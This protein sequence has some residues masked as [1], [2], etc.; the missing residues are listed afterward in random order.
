MI[1]PHKISIDRI[2]PNYISGWCYHRIRKGEV[3]NLCIRYD[4]EPIAETLADRF[5]EDL[6]ELNMH[7]T[8]KCGFEFILDPPLSFDEISSITLTLRNS[9]KPLVIIEPDGYRFGTPFTALFERTKQLF[10]MQF[11]RTPLVLFMHI[12]KTA[13]TTFNTDLQS[14]V[15]T[16]KISQHIELEKPDRLSS[17]G[18]NKA[19]LSG[20]LRFGLL[21][22]YFHEQEYL[23]Y[24]I[25]RDPYNHLHSHLN[26]M[27]KTA[28]GND[29]NYFKYSNPIIYR[30]GQKLAE[31]QFNYPPDLQAFVEEISPLE[32]RFFDNLQTRYF[33]R[34]EIDRVT[35]NNLEE[36]ISNLRAFQLVG[37]TEAYESFLKTFIAQH[38]FKTMSTDRQLNRS[39]A[40]PLFDTADEG[41]QNT[42][43]PL[44]QYDV[45]LYNTI[46]KQWAEHSGPTPERR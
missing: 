7:P 13:G 10:S 11:R 8:G 34:N 25:V 18:R 38:G 4:N 32:A 35:K 17:L 31:I 15:P 45:I 30:L 1:F 46:K 36:A 33:C 44:V 16:N 3:V 24:T 14:I 6:F 37:L 28:V 40:E 21:E 39:T 19:V 9:T 43:Y 20:H 5:R 42:L 12:P 41:L 23:L 27:I 26:W 2:N 22:T 29:D